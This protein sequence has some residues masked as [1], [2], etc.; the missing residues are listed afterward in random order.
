[1]S[2]AIKLS[3]TEE[4]D[5]Q[6]LAKILDKKSINEYKRLLFVRSGDMYATD[7]AR[8]HIVHGVKYPDGEYTI[9]RGY[10]N[11]EKSIAAPFLNAIKMFRENA[12]NPMPGIES[13]A[14]NSGQITQ[15][16]CE[17]YVKYGI[18][19]NYEYLKLLFTAAKSWN[20]SS[21]KDFKKFPV[22]FVSGD[23]EVFIM[24]MKAMF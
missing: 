13:S 10:L 9:D 15:I 2:D 24:P 16:V 11:A 18:M 7:G 17:M 20:V 12:V 5:V 23:K 22:Q 21:P 3:K 19:I 8:A 4:K 6:W 1:M 14:T